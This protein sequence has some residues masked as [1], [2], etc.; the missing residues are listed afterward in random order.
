MR[1]S[2]NGPSQI[3]SDQGEETQ[4]Q[5]KRGKLDA[6]RK[7]WT[8]TSNDLPGASTFPGCTRGADAQEDLGALQVSGDR[9][10]QADP[11]DGARFLREEVAGADP[12]RLTAILLAITWFDERPYRARGCRVL[13]HQ[14]ASPVRGVR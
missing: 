4:P 7:A 13:G 11:D 2:V 8:I 10:P 12:E 3:F 9:D 1:I 5:E 6:K 14:G